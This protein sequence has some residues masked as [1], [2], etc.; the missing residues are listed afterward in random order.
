MSWLKAQKI[1]QIH[2]RAPQRLPTKPVIVQKPLLYFQLD[3]TGPF[4]RDRGF[5]WIMGIV[6]V[7][8]KM[9]YTAALKNKTSDN[10][11]RALQRIISENNLNNRVIQSDNGGEFQGPEILELFNKYSVVGR[12][13]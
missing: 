4:S 13:K 9:L 8:T 7:S 2:V 12:Q 5:K 11:A 6:D 1:H 3:L 10:V